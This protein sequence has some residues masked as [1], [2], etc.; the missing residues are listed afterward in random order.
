VTTVDRQQINFKGN[1]KH[2]EILLNAL[3]QKKIRIW[4]EWR[5]D[6]S[7]ESPNLQG[8]NLIGA[9]LTGVDFIGADLSE[10][11]LSKAELSSSDLSGIILARAALVETRFIH[12]TIYGGGLGKANLQNANLDGAVLN[13]ATLSQAN[14]TGAIIRGI[15]RTDWNIEDIKCDYVFTDS[16]GEMRE[17]K[18]RDFEPGEFEKLYKDLPKIEYTFLDDFTVIDIIVMDQIV[19]EIN[20]QHPGHE[21]KLDSFN[22][23]GRPRA[24]FTIL[25]RKQAD[26]IL[27]KIE[28][29]YKTKIKALEGKIKDIEKHFALVTKHPQ[30]IYDIGNM[31]IGDAYNINGPTGAVGPQA[32]AYDINFNQLWG[33]VSSEIDL[34]KLAEDLLQ[35][36]QELKEKAKED[37]H[38]RAI[39]E[40]EEAEIAAKE[41]K[42]PKALE[43]LKNAGKWTFSVAEKIGTSLA[44]AA[45]KTA[46]GL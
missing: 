9:K 25:D 34:P 2:L 36:R 31:Y 44:T 8:V 41:G 5:M 28:T 39:A 24:V 19:Q 20:I 15:S 35:L 38:Y 21:L 27:G 18:D 10:A 13:S 26:T 42:G 14:L 11:D 29:K 30:I 6:N 33:E 37:E 46:L 32:S 3:E 1:A 7:S 12:S 45:L 4:N 17:P 43:H 16:N 40:V 22:H 23:R